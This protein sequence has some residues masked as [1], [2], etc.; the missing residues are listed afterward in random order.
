VSDSLTQSWALDLGYRYLD[1]GELHTGDELTLNGGSPVG[2]YTQRGDLQAHEV[3]VG[4][5]YSF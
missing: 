3:Q 2:G 4:L 5:R 1:M